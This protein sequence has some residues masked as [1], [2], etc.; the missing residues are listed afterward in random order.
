MNKLCAFQNLLGPLTGHPSMH[1]LS[2]AYSCASPEKACK[3]T[4]STQWLAHN[5][6][7]KSSFESYLYG[8]L[9]ALRNPVSIHIGTRCHPMASTE[10]PTVCSFKSDY[11]E[12]PMASTERPNQYVLP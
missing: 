9:D 2:L 11:G 6:I 4:K 5:S 8:Q 1:S 3:K 10:R 12:H 7:S